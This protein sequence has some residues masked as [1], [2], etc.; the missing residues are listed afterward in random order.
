M[1]AQ[2][3]GVGAQGLRLSGLVKDYCPLERGPEDR[4]TCLL[5][6]GYPKP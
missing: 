6:G 4:L 1:D 3:D 2:K 5:G